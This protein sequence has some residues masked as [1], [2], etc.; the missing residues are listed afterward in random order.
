MRKNTTDLG[1]ILITV[2]EL[3][4][5]T[6][7]ISSRR[8]R[9]L[10]AEGKIPPIKRGKLP[11]LDSIRGICAHFNRVSEQTQRE[12]LALLTA[13]RKARELELSVSEGK[14]GDKKEAETRRVA[15][16][17]RYH[18][19]VSSAIETDYTR[20]R[21]EFL[22]GHAALL[23]D[24]VGLFREFDAKLAQSLV[25]KIEQ[26]CEEEGKKDD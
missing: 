9:Q 17:R 23:P 11:M 14:Y 21:I 19:I 12:R 26:E 25:D 24:L 5:M 6:G 15:V 13:N 7:V 18:Q 8:V 10:S 16:L 20:Q 2:D 22:Q 4:S 1:A 3:A